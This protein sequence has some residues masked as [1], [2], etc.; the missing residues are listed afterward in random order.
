MTPEEI[1]YH[2]GRIEAKIDAIDRSVREMRTSSPVQAASQVRDV[3]A[4]LA[5]LD[6]SMNWLLGTT[7][8]VFL[9]ALLLVI[10]IWRRPLQR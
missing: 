5:R 2:L 10:T 6:Q 1:S 4:A 3:D 8:L 7:V 9:V